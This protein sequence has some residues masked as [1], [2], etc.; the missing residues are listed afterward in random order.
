M[1]TFVW[2]SVDRREATFWIIQFC[3]DGICTNSH[4][5]VN[6]TTIEAKEISNIFF[7][8]FRVLTG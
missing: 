8:F 2:S 4:R 5:A 7:S 1:A 3:T 6:K